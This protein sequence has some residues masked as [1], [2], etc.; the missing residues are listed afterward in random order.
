MTKELLT[1]IITSSNFQEYFSSNSLKNNK[2]Q[3]K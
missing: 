2:N 3:L 1:I